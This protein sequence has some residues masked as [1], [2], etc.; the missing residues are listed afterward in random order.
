M[1]AIDPSKDRREN[2]SMLRLFGV[3]MVRPSTS[4]INMSSSFGGALEQL[5]WPSGWWNLRRSAGLQTIQYIGAVMTDRTTFDT[6]TR[7]AAGDDGTNYDNVAIAL[8]WTT[9]ALVL[10]Q[11]LTAFTWDWFPKDTQESLQSLHTS[12]GV[13]LTVVIVARVIWRLMPGHQVP[14]IEVGWVKIASKSVHYLLYVALVC[15]AAL[16]LTIGWAAGHPIH[17]FGLPIPGPIG[18]LARP[19]RHDIREI[20]QLLGYTIVV[21]A[22]GH[23]LAALYHHYAR[24]DRVLGRMFPPA[25]RSETAA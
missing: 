1:A 8:H 12:F 6:A 2:A 14:S 10:I 24:H 25:R 17:L 16:G 4:I 13:L 22:F 5:R 21:I 19:L 3:A 23:A 20:H 9:A 18:A 11:F 7:I 15:Q